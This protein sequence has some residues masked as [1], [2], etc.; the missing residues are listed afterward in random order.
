VTFTLDGRFLISTGW[1]GRATIW[2]IASGREVA[3]LPA[4]LPA[5]WNA[6]FSPN[7]KYFMGCSS[8][9]VKLWSVLKADMTED[10]RPRFSFEPSPGPQRSYANSACFSPDSRLVA[11][12][13][14]DFSNG[15]TQLSVWDLSKAEGR[16]WPVTVFPYLAL[17]FMPDSRHLALVNSEKGLV[18]VRDAITGELSK[19]FGDKEL[20]QGSAIHTALSSDGAWLAVGGSKAVTIWDLNKQE[21]VLA[22]PEERGT[23]WSLAW[24][25]NKEL[26][27]VGS[28]DGGLFIWNLPKI[29]TELGQ[30]GLSW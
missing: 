20:L 18:E 27:A 15:A 10:G 13:D 25:P 9:G 2:E 22:L 23:V 24:S 5:H 11:W 30:I 7:G 8:Y 16:S 28:S 12:I 26:L 19:S 4:E 1:L 3:T 21:L 29:K 6:A 14:F 17:S